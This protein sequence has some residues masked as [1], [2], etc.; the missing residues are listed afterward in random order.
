M[1]LSLVGLNMLALAALLAAAYLIFIST[2]SFA[3]VP[4][5]GQKVL[6]GIFG[7]GALAML[8]ASAQFAGKRRMNPW[9]AITP[10]VIGALLIAAGFG[11]LILNATFP[12]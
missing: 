5:L 11:W 10:M 3:P 12:R 7:T 1:R 6:L 4:E 2:Q 8:V 9:G